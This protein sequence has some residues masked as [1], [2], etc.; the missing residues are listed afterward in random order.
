MGLR[1]RVKKPEQ[2]TREHYD[3]LRLSDGTEVRYTAE[4]GQAAF[5]AV[6]LEEEEGH[7]LLPHLRRAEPKTA[8][9]NLVWMLEGSLD[10]TTG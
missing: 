6:L 1:D 10:G 7:W 9:S 3:V 8:L 2:K 4:D 5:F